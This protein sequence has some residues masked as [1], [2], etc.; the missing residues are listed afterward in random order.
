MFKRLSGLSLGIIACIAIYS[1][2]VLAHSSKI[3]YRQIEAMEIRAQYDNGSPMVKAQ[4]VVYA[5]DNPNTP[6]LK[7]MTDLEGKFVFAPDVSI[8]GSWTV[9]VRL[10]GH[11]SIV[12]IPFE[13][14]QEEVENRSTTTGK[15]VSEKMITQSN[16]LNQTDTS[17]RTSFQ[18][19][20]MAATGVWGFV[21]TALFFSR[22]SKK[23]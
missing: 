8:A 5:P 16:T 10:G 6:W 20:V 22:K 2:I 7:G 14:P 1:P 11:G 12:H 13:Q 18:K 23:V 3:R 15:N 21:G 17:H 19:L 9:K 4:V